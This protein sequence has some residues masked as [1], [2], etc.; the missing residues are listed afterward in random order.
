M[1]R[2]RAYRSKIGRLPFNV[3]NELCERIRDGATGIA[4][5]KWLNATP[6]WSKIKAEFGGIDIN[7]VNLSDWREMGYKEWIG[8]QAEADRLRKTTE[9]AF[10]MVSAAG[11]DP[12]TVA[13]RIIAARLIQT[14]EDVSDPKALAGTALAITGLKQADIREKRLALSKDALEL[15]RQK[16]MRQSCELF[17]KWSAD[18]N[19]AAIVAG[20][21]TNQ[22]KIEALLSV[23]GS[24]SERKGLR[25]ER[26]GLFWEVIRLLKEIQPPWVVLEN[27]VGLLSCNDG[28]DFQAV[29]EALADCG[30]LGCWRT[31]NAQYFGVP[32]ARRRVFVVGGLDRFP[33]ADFLLDAGPVEAIPPSAGSLRLPRSA[34]GSVVHTLTAKKANCGISIGCEVLVAEEGR[35]DKMADRERVS[36]DHGIPLGLDVPDHCQRHASGN[37]VVPAVAHWVAEK[38]L[39]SMELHQ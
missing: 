7:S 1:Q 23:M 3:R 32:T 18:Q 19:A 25:G 10:A 31:L 33:A 29:L 34:H 9:S 20:P 38:I 15:D 4:I 5:L 6:E 11:G 36:R 22:Q 12:S 21:G 26:S 28:E 24:M 2:T 37:A 27:V 16:F 13:A 17:I 39:M 8:N 35:W 30:Y 14:M